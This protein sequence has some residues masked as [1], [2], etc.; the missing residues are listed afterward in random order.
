M[1]YIMK[2][3]KGKMLTNAKHLLAAV[4]RIS[5]MFKSRTSQQL[6]KGVSW[7]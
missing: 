3:H 6:Q 2:I 7:D 4:R 1:H 5:V